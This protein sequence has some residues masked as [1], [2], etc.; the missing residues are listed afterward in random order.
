[1]IFRS[2]DSWSTTLWIDVGDKLRVRSGL[3]RKSHFFH[4]QPSASCRQN[5]KSITHLNIQNHLL[6]ILPE[7]EAKMEKRFDE[8]ARVADIAWIERKIIF[9]IQCSPISAEEIIARNADYQSL[10]FQVVWILHEDRFNKD[11]LFPAELALL[12]NPHYFSNI[13]ENGFGN[14]YDQLSI[15]SQGKRVYR[16]S[17]YPINLKEIKTP[18]KIKTALPFIRRRQEAWSLS[19]QDDVLDRYYKGDDTIKAECRKFQDHYL[20]CNQEEFLFNYLRKKIKQK[21]ILPIK[22]FFRL[23]LEK[24][25][26]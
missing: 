18:K 23:I 13:D 9:E 1:V 26:N 24:A 10:G 15:I 21:L 2:P 8:I 19:F 6:S 5:G 20:E 11:K 17:K 4:I 7:N 25:C 12:D 14:I 22:A 3:Y 16:F